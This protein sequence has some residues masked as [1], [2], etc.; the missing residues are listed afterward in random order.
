MLNRGLWYYLCFG[1]VGGREVEKIDKEKLQRP[2]DS[3]ITKIMARSVS[4]R[5]TPRLAKTSITPLQV[6]IGSLFLGLC[7]ALV[8]SQTNWA[9]CLS[10]A[11]LLECSHVLDC[12]DGELA[13]LTG[14]GSP[15]AASL[16]PIS[17]RI[18]DAAIIYSGT[19]HALTAGVLN[20]SRGQIFTIGFLAL[21]LWNLYMYIVDAYLNPAR[22]AR[23][24]AMEMKGGGIYLGLYDFFIYGSIF[25]WIS[26]LFEYFI[27]FVTAIAFAGT[28]IQVERLRRA[29]KP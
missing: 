4:A 10:A 12:V 6:T 23:A 7:A 20:M 16:D 24:S 29:L 1:N 11:V 17:D 9:F 21:G 5:I 18:K 28:I 26:S 14:R 13:R 15:F 3:I 25:F 22:R 19:V 27:L 8:G 2:N